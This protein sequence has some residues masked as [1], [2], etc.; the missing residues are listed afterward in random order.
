MEEFNNYLKAEDTVVAGGL[1]TISV[2]ILTVL[3]TSGTPDVYS[4]LSFYLLVF[5]L[6]LLVTGLL[7]LHI[8]H[9]Q[10]GNKISRILVD[11]SEYISARTAF[12]GVGL[13]ICHVSEKA[14]GIFFLS[15]L[16]CYF[17]FF[18]ILKKTKKSLELD[19]KKLAKQKPH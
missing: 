4:R 1:I 10:V 16:F 13:A 2:I 12:L 7:I 8:P 6:P 11:Y 18:H 19:E 5:S 9:L 17:L 15:S 3:L 14:T